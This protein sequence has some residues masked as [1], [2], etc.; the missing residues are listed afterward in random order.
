MP[1]LDVAWAKTGILRWLAQS[2]RRTFLARLW[3]FRPELRRGNYVSHP[4]AQFEISQT[5]R[6]H[7]ASP[8]NPTPRT[9]DGTVVAG[10]IYFV[11]P[12][13]AVS[14]VWFKQTSGSYFQDDPKILWSILIW[15]MC[16]GLVLMRW[17][18]SQGGRRFAWGT[19]GLF[20]FV[21]LT[22]W[23]SSLMSPLHS[24]NQQTKGD[25]MLKNSPAKKLVIRRSS[26]VIF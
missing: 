25:S 2:A 4:G 24:P 1:G 7:F 16:L 14:A 26:F 17:K 8:A 20:I 23:G 3:R 22:F 9:G 10:R 11:E 19:I 5:A 18:F 13:L 15:V 6:R 12:S 21:A